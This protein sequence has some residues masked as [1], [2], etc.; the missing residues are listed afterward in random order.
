MEDFPLLTSCKAK[1]HVF[2]KNCLAFKKKKKSKRQTNILSTTIMQN[3]VL[4]LMC[5]NVSVPEPSS[6][7][8]ESA[9]GGGYCPLFTSVLAFAI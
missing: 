8:G 2:L 7:Y 1:L 6:T 4:I 3:S 5:K 9:E